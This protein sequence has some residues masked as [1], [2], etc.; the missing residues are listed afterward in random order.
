MAKT[1]DIFVTDRRRR[2]WWWADNAVID[3][4]LSAIGGQAL[5]VYC[6]LVRFSAEAGDTR[7]ARVSMR[8]IEA[9]T[10]TT[11][12]TVRR[13]MDSLEKAGLVRVQAGPG[14]SHDAAN[15][16]D[17]LSGDGAEQAEADGV[18][19]RTPS[20]S[21]PRP[22]AHPVAESLTADSQEVDGVH[23]RTPCADDGGHERPPCSAADGVHRRTPSTGAPRAKIA[24]DA[25]VD[26]TST[27]D[28]CTLEAREE[29][30]EQE[31]PP[32]PLA[33]P[34]GET[35]L[36]FGTAAEETAQQSLLELVAP[37]QPAA[38]QASGD[39]RDW[40]EGD[41]GE[42]FRAWNDTCAP[43]GLPRCSKI[44][45]NRRIRARRLLK[46]HP[47]AECRE[48]MARVAKS[49][50]CHGEE[51]DSLGQVRRWSSTWKASIDWLLQP[52]VPV[53]ILEGL[54][55]DRPG[56]PSRHNLEGVEYR[57]APDGF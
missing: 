26:C 1:P 37:E 14:G 45:D 36:H 18:H 33:A 21:A 47:L 53:K 35:S 10:G 40:P 11:R 32:S 34:A 31:Y 17:I 24:Q 41:M 22:P 57:E 19:R 44:T 51:I 15:V 8:V 46:H 5:A 25:R 12:S 6:V 20:T 43:T 42:L 50:W 28:S 30:K 9:A 52:D 39:N 13:A 48:M 4:H 55:D 16:Y 7:S 27:L 3:R 38:D 29:K 23:G 56:Q 54:C 49:R 2:G